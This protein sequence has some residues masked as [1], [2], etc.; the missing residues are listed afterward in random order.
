MLTAFNW[1]EHTPYNVSPLD[2]QFVGYLDEVLDMKFA[3]ESGELLV[4]ANNSEQLKVF[5]RSSS[6]CQLLAGHGGVILALDAS[7]NGRMLA[8]GSK[9][10]T[11]R[12]WQ[13]DGTSGQFTCVAVGT[14]H[15]HAVGA[16]AVSRYS[17][18]NY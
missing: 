6:S 14:G 3:G 4:V 18:I 10:S 17:V 2:A 1:L 9:D 7:P 13:L 12:M 8:T 11:I 5:N 15:T 16:V